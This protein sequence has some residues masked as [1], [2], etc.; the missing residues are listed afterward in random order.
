MVVG[1][2][3]VV[4]ASAMQ[5]RMSAA[6]TP[7]SCIARSLP[8]AREVDFFDRITM[9]YK[10]TATAQNPQRATKEHEDINSQALIL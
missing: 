1:K 3:G 8:A 10:I 9:I 7:I 4:T 2:A 6:S 5:S